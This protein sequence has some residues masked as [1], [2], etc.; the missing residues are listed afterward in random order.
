[1]MPKA[2]GECVLVFPWSLTRRQH[3]LGRLIDD[4]LCGVRLQEVIHCGRVL[5][6]FSAVMLPESLHSTLGF[7]IKG[8][9]QEKGCKAFLH[10]VHIH[11]FLK[12]GEVF[13]HLERR[14]SRITILQM[15]SH[16]LKETIRP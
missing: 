12:G 9:R 1:M 14:R 4:C 10:P 8:V 2:T 3:G 11:R 5:R 6:H 15:V 13:N 16:P 7:A